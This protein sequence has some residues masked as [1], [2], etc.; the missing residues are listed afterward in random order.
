MDNI[1]KRIERLRKERKLTQQQ[2]ANATGIT[3]GNIS[4][5]ESGRFYPSITTTIALARFFNVSIDW[6]LTGKEKDTLNE[7][8][9]KLLDVYSR[10]DEGD[11]KQVYD[12]CL[13]LLYKK[14]GY[15][16]NFLCHKMSNNGNYKD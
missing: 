16:D 7:E 10:L 6:L 11:K 9:K 13:F 3:R 8:Q 4:S 12:Y 2:L 1:G 5:Y 15:P 14:L